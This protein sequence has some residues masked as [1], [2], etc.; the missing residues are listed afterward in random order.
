MALIKRSKLNPGTAQPV[1]EP[2][3]IRP[4]A[5]N[6]KPNGAARRVSVPSRDKLSER[7]AAATEELASGL[8]EASAAAEELRRSMEQIAS[9]ASEAAG[10]SQEQLAAIKQVVGQPRCGA[11][12][13]RGVAPPHRSRRGRAGGNRDPDRHLGARHRTQRPAPGRLGGR[14]IAELERRAQDIGEITARGQPDLGPDQPS[15]AQCRDRGGARR[16]SRPR[17]RRRRRRSARARRD[18]GEKRAGRPE[19]RDRRSRPTFARSPPRSRRPPRR[20]SAK[21]RPA[22]PSLTS[23]MACAKTCRGS[24]KAARKS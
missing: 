13:S 22:P 14:L 12:A 18:L 4:P 7:L 24:P 20:R 3:P 2:P 8:T 23:W 19:A 1:V 9:G 15:R 10:A 16:R 11:H 21:R 17:L 6:G 5:R